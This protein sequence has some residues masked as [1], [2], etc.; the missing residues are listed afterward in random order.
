MPIADRTLCQIC[1]VVNQ[2]WLGLRLDGLGT[3]LTFAIALFTCLNHSISPASGGLAL[4]YMLTV[5]QSLSWLCR[6]YA[7]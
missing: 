5:Q 7:E 3:C 1:T 6:Q 4:S 2:R